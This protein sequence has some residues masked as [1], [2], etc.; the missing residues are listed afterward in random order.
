MIPLY[1]VDVP[2]FDPSAYNNNPDMYFDHPMMLQDPNMMYN[3]QGGGSY[4]PNMP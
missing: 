3:N 1:N 4:M 2:A